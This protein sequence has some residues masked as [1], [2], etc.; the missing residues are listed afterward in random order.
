MYREYFGT[1]VEPFGVSPDPRFFFP[2]PLHAEASASVYYA[3]AER[4]GFAL[5][6][7]RPGLGK[8]SVLVNLAARLSG[9]AK[10]AFIVHPSLDGDS[11]LNSLL[12][13]MGLDPHP[14]PVRRLQQ[15][16]TFLLDLSKQGKTAVVIIDEAQNLSYGALEAI[17]MLSNFEAPTQKLI[18]FILAGQPALERMLAA[19]ECE[20][21]VQRISSVIRLKPLSKEQVASY[22]RHRLA[23]AG[24]EGS[25]F[26]AAALSVIAE[27]SGGVPRN[28]NKI[29]F[30]AL[31]LAF[32]E[33][34]K[35][36]G[37]EL[38]RQAA[39]EGELEG[40]GMSAARDPETEPAERNG[41]SGIPNFALS[42]RSKSL[43]LPALLTTVLTVAALLCMG[44][45]ARFR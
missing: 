19:P 12:L 15:F 4:R 41:Y 35:S 10:V 5:L 21:I 25:P 36:V 22:I 44:L 13:A 26:S 9:E 29:C 24:V 37:A 1:S 20:Q 32:A 16:H 33:S 31:T 23:V 6:V 3:I 2:S 28:I 18:Q 34:K 43:S 42:G 30:N 38:I 7:G 8:T 45:M 17:R 39:S 40:S 11:V 14:D 27:L